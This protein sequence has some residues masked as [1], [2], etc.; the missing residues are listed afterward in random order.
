MIVSQFQERR[1]F[2]GRLDEG[3]DIIAGF[4]AICTENRVSCAWIQAV[5]VLAH[6]R[7]ESFDGEQ[8]LL[9]GLVYCPTVSG[10][11]SV[12]GEGIDIRLYSSVKT[13]GEGSPKELC[14]RLLAGEVKT[15]EFFLLAL[16]DV[17]F[18]RDENSVFAPWVQVQTSEAL[19]A[20]VQVPPPALQPLT[21]PPQET[22]LPDS[23]ET[24]ELILMQIQPGDYLDHPR[25]GLCRV[26]NPPREDHVSVRLGSGKNVDL[27]TGVIRI[28]PPRESGGKRI[29]PVELRRR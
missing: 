22:R 12:F 9:N 18:V 16:D 7:F 5:A 28:L 3:Q 10:N 27:H 25:F 8:H 26:V 11:V 6:V 23:D 13:L 21:R 29:F 2:V 1:Y 24:D 14:G 19:K 15:C 17:T 20:R 4:K